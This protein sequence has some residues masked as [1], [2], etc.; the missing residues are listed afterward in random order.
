LGCSSAA[1]DTSTESI[2][3]PPGALSQARETAGLQ[4]VRVSDSNS[5]GIARVIFFKI[6]NFQEVKD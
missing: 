2:W 3:L 1:P 6:S 5:A 4:L